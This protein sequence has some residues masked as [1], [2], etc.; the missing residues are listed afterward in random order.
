MGFCLVNF[1]AAAALEALAVVD[2]DVAV[3]DIDV[4]FGNGSADILKD[5][6][7]VRYASVHE[8]GIYPGTGDD[9]P[10]GA[11]ICKLPVPT[12]CDPSLWLENVRS[13][14]EFLRTE[15][16][17]VLIV[18]IGYDALLE[19]TLAG[20]SLRS[21]DYLAVIDMITSKFPTERIMWG[22]EGGYDLDATAGAIGDTIERLNQRE[23]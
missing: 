20:L 1:A 18:S 6:D 13:A 21:S 9:P 16:T 14:V 7:G 19:D 22:L 17:K 2:G 8:S 15:H 10:E 12:A 3:L 4:H 23:N 5:L 11:N